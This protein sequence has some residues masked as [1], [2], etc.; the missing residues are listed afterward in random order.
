MRGE[1]VQ[2]KLYS[3]GTSSFSKLSPWEP[4]VIDLGC[5][6]GPGEPAFLLRTESASALISILLLEMKIIDE[7][8]RSDLRCFEMR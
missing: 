6:S 5:F 2:L 7:R 1:T 8:E 3:K 4:C